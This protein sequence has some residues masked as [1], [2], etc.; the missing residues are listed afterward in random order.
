[1]KVLITDLGDD[2]EISFKDNGVGLQGRDKKKIFKKYYRVK[3]VVK[4]SGIGL[5][6]AQH[7]AKLHR[8]SLRAESAGVGEGSIFYIKFRKENY[9]I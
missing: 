2:V 9:A 4:G 7:I 8:G 1:M 6:L 3:K 5:Y